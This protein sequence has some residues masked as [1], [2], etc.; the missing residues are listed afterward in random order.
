MKKDLPSLL[1]MD[2]ELQ[3]KRCDFSNGAACSSQYLT[4]IFLMRRKRGCALSPHSQ[5]RV[6]VTA[7]SRFAWFAEKGFNKLM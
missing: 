6:G 2:Q 4:Y 7:F 1:K 5:S 3:G